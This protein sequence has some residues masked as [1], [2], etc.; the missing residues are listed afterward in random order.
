MLRHRGA[1]ATRHLM[2]KA[3]ITVT[4]AAALSSQQPALTQYSGSGAEAPSEGGKY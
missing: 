1:D 2:N 4:C 3:Y